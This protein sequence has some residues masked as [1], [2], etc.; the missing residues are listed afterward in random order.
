MVIQLEAFANRRGGSSA[1]HYS[2]FGSIRRR[3][4]ESAVGIARHEVANLV[5]HGLSATRENRLAAIQLHGLSAV[6]L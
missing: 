3:Q 1:E 6:H 2:Q 5:C 4:H